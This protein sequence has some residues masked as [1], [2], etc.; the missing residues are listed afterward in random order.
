MENNF[1]EQLRAWQQQGRRCVEIK[2]GSAGDS[3]VFSIFAYDYDLGEGQHVSSVE[4]FEQFSSKHSNT[5]TCQ[6]ILF[7]LISPFLIDNVDHAILLQDRHKNIFHASEP[8]THSF[9]AAFILEIPDSLLHI[10]QYASY[11]IL[12]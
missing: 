7:H 5:L 4:D 2:M 8:F 10:L 12:A 3:S 9:L 6:F 11:F 1:L